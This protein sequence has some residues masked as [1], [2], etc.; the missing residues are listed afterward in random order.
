[1]S[2]TQDKILSAQNRNELEQTSQ[3]GF[4]EDFG[5]KDFAQKES[6]TA[7]EKMD[8]LLRG[9]NSLYL[10]KEIEK[11]RKEAAKFRLASKNEAEQRILFQEKTELFEK[12]LAEL[13]ESHK[14]LKIMRALDKAGCL[15]SE[16]VAKDIP[17]NCENLEDFIEA[18]KGENSFLFKV[19]KQNISTTFKS[20]GSK[21]LS[22]AQKMDAYIR[23]ALG[24]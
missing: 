1:M 15:K 18:Y 21:N 24:R 6:K 10:K 12:E 13:K 23:A 5:E 19:P 20:S 17:A 11:L 7:A 8:S 16:L 9:N 22:A 2:G 4:D 3:T 14:N